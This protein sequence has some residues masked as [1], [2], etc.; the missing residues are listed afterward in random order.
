MNLLTTLLYALPPAP[1]PKKIRYVVAK[2]MRTTPPDKN[3]CR[4]SIYGTVQPR[5]FECLKRQGRMSTSDIIRE[6]DI[7]PCS[8]RRALRALQDRK[9]VLRI[10]RANSNATAEWEAL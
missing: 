7:N 4:T 10:R 1:L 6:L 8:I 2:E 9:M 5:I 3:L